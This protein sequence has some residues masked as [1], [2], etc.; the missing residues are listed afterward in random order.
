[1][2]ISS[3]IIYEVDYSKESI[4]EL[5]HEIAYKDKKEQSLLFNYPTVYIV[6]QNDKKDYTVYI[7]ETANI[8]RRMGE[9]I[10]V[11]PVSRTDWKKLANSKTAKMFV[12]GHEFF[13][14]SLTLDIE[15]RLIQYMMSV[16]SVK[17]IN[18]RRTNPQNEYF[19][20]KVFEKVF[21]KVWRELHRRNK[22]LFPVERII[23]DSA[24]FKA[25]PFHKLTKEQMAAKDSI[26]LKITEALNRN[27]TEQ[28][29][30]VEGE[31]GSGKTVLMSSLFY[32]LYEL[33]RD[34][35]DNKVLHNIKSFLLVN[36]PE[37]LK[38]YEQIAKKL[39][40]LTKENPDVVS[41]P[42]SFINKHTEEEQVD[43]LI[44]DEA[45][46]LWTQG[47]Q[48]YQGKNQLKD[49]LK[50]AKV[51]VAVF[52]RNQILSREQY[53]EEQ[54]LEEIFHEANLKNNYIHL[55]NQLRINADEETIH[56]IRHFIDHREILNIPED[57]KKYDIQIFEH[58]KE[59]YDKIA[60]KAENEEAGIS[61]ML[62]TF[63]WKYVNNKA[64]DN[65]EDM[66]YVKIGNW[67]MPW[68]LQ[69]KK[70]QT[71]EV[72]Q[73]NQGRAWAEQSYTI[74]E[75][76]STFTIQGFDLNYAGLIIG[77]SVKYRNGKI[78]FDRT[79]SKNKKATEQRT[80]KNGSKVCVAD[81]LLKN[82]LNVLMTRGVNGLYIY[83]L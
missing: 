33:A 69:L 20:S 59:M 76:G 68:N 17:R 22:K 77:P 39:G 73:Q 18:N 10:N 7:G 80:L 27:K 66:W 2:K 64:P 40:I 58:P 26:I 28:L 74:N 54:E 9:H 25:S 3:P 43:V 36:H 14:K 79:E 8:K 24:L 16:E 53:W 57:T 41:K 81:F 31:A 12:I 1:M 34:D 83:M 75:V 32:E 71:K 19:T 15:N 35:S 65:G 37:Q 72:R 13:N 52:D 38:V 5:E 29:I 61:R 42:T 4:E 30:V 51:V 55:N 49:L 45:H 60:L 6:N 50:R 44:V 70:T 48:S 63:D 62:A 23:K 56:W 67:K 47:K 82:E 78:I 21:S 11:D 46:L